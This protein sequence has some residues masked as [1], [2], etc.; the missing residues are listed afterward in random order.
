[1]NE[2]KTADLTKYGYR[3]LKEA[4][5]LL[6]AYITDQFEDKNFFLFNL[7]LNFDLKIII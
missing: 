7:S 1:M 6:K 3:E 4:N 2:I 5:K